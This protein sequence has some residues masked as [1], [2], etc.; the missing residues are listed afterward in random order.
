MEVDRRALWLRGVLDLCVLGV[1]VSAEG[2]G[3]GL[4]Q[5][6]ETAGLSRIKGGTL[7]PVLARLE[8]AGLVA[9][10][11]RLG[12]H[13]PGRKYYV[14]TEAGEDVLASQGR[15]WRA[16]TDSTRSLLDESGLNE[17]RLP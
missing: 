10:E 12:A 2:H 17:R 11:W 4:I 16:F 15:A 8:Q 1:L 13:G 5:R 3:Y 6:L 14:L 7:Y 9:A